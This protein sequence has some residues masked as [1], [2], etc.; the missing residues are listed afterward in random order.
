MT[1]T[2]VCVTVCVYVTVCVLL[3]DIFINFIQTKYTCK[4]KKQEE[5]K[6][7][8]SSSCDKKRRAE[9]S[10]Y[11]TPPR[12]KTRV[13]FGSTVPDWMEVMELS[14]MEIEMLPNREQ[15]SVFKK[16]QNP[17]RKLRTR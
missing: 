11:V 9:I 3:I 12:N 7:V 5:R 6:A 16:Q 14:G 4:K 10:A 2:C 8:P 13:T 1:V 17:R 15:L